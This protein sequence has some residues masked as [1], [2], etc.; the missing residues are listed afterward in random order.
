MSGYAADEVV[1]RNVQILMPATY[2]EEHDGYLRGPT[3]EYGAER[4]MAR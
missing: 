4:R 3:A 2:R 1:G